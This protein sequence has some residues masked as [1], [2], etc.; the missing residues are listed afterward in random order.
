MNQRPAVSDQDKPARSA[1]FLQWST[2]SSYVPLLATIQLAN[3]SWRV[4]PAGVSNSNETVPSAIAYF[5]LFD[6]RPDQVGGLFK[7]DLMDLF[8]AIV[9]QPLQH[10][11][12][13]FIRHFLL[14]PMA[15]IKADYVNFG[16]KIR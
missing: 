1:S 12:G 3:S 9:F 16:Y 6:A 11:A 2:Q 8:S 15:A 4:K 5:D 10:C 7:M 14:D 13:R